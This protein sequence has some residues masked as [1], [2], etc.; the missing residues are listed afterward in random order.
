MNDNFIYTRLMGCLFSF[1][2]IKHNNQTVLSRNCGFKKSS[3][4]YVTKKFDSKL[5]LLSN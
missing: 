2:V 1:N 3:D 5:I 4:S